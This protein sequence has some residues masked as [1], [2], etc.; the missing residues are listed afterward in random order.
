MTTLACL[1][2]GIRERASGGRAAIIELSIL[3]R[4]LHSRSP[5]RY[6]NKSSRAR[7]PASYA[8]YDNTGNHFITSQSK[9]FS[10][11]LFSSSLVVKRNLLVLSVLY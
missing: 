8:G 7:N 2:G 1:A 4:L 3:S 11:L 9:T 10:A 6:E 5:L